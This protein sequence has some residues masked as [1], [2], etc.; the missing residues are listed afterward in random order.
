MTLNIIKGHTMTTINQP[1][2]PVGS[3]LLIAWLIKD[4]TPR[5]SA[6]W[7]GITSPATETTW[8]ENDQIGEVEVVEYSPSGKYVRVK[9]PGGDNYM[10]GPTAGWYPTMRII[11]KEVLTQ[12][13][14][15]AG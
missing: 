8:T 15:D 4:T 12:R 7:G 5:H 9:S 1:N 11:V 2:Y 14:S 6:T 10:H 3:R 13:V